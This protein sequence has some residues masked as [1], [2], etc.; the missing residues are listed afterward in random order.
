MYTNLFDTMMKKMT[1]VVPGSDR[2]QRKEDRNGHEDSHGDGHEDGIDGGKHSKKKHAADTH[3]DDDDNE[4][5][6]SSMLKEIYGNQQ[7]QVDKGTTYRPSE[8]NSA[9]YK[10]RTLKVK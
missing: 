1:T 4:G 6:G 8:S 10:P 7:L 9:E 3:D 2:S 5:P